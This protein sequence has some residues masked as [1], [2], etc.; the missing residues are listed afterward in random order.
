MDRMSWAEA[1]SFMDGFESKRHEIWEM[2]RRV[3]HAMFQ[4][5][6]TKRLELEDVLHF[7][8]DDESDDIPDYNERD[9]ETVRHKA[10]KIKEL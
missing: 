6:S 4:S 2:V 8:W 10:M 7:P 5:Q 9:L 3:V 1:E